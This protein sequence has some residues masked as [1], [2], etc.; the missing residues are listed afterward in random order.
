VHGDGVRA[1]RLALWQACHR[2][3]RRTG[4]LAAVSLLQGTVA[5]G[6]LPLGPCG[7]AFVPE[8]VATDA[9][10]WYRCGIVSRR[11]PDQ[12]T[13]V[14]RVPVDGGTLVAIRHRDPAEA[15]AGPDFGPDST[16]STDST[17]SDSTDS[18][19][20]TVG[21]VWIR[22]GVNA[23]LLDECLRYLGSRTSGGAPLVRQQMVRGALASAFGDQLEIEAM[24]AAGTGQLG[25]RALGQLHT[26]LTGNG[27]A[28]LRLLGASSFV[29]A[30][31]GQAA[32]ASELLASAYGAAQPVREQEPRCQVTPT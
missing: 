12:E 5:A 17:D 7:Y 20:W 15:P 19:D 21:V 16:D 29:T 1:G 9:R 26:Q 23:G 31:P 30:G 3:A 11:L 6:L 10:G 28:L 8:Q 32:Y 18:T 4:P 24:L 27:R 25:E 2:T 22:A 14:Q 13:L